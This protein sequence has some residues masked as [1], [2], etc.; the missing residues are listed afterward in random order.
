M[1]GTKYLS[2]LVNFNHLYLDE[3][4]IVQAPTGSGKTYFTLHTIPEMCKDPLHQALYLIDTIN[5]K[6]QILKNYNARPA[7]YN[8]INDIAEGYGC[9]WETHDE[10]VVIM[11]YALF[12]EIL[13]SK[14]D[15]GKHFQ[16]IICDELP[17]LIKF[18]N[19]SRKPNSHSIAKEELEHITTSNTTIVIALTATPRPVFK[20]FKAPCRLIPIDQGELRHYETKTTKHYYSI[21]HLISTMDVSERGLCFAS[22]I[23]TMKDIEAMAVAHEE[24]DTAI[25]ENEEF[26][27]TDNDNSNDSMSVSELVEEINETDEAVEDETALLK[28]E[29]AKKIKLSASSITVEW[30]S[31]FEL[32]AYLEGD[33]REQI[34]WNSAYFNPSVEFSMPG[35]TV[36]FKPDWNPGTYKIHA[37]ANNGYETAECEVT[38]TVPEASVRYRTHVQKIGWQ[39]YVQDGEL[40]GTTG[41]SLRLE[42]INIDVSGNPLIHEESLSYRTHVQTYG[43]QAWKENNEMA[44]TSGES[45][46]LEAIRIELDSEFYDIYYQTHVQHFGWT[47]WACNGEDCG[48]AGY[49]YRLE[50]IRIKLV[51]KGD[52][53]PGNTLNRYYV[54]PSSGAAY[55]SPE[56]KIAGALIGYNTH[57]QSYGWQSWVQYGE[58]SG[59]YGLGKRLEG[60]QI[61]LTGNL[62]KNY[63]IYYCVHAQTYGWLD[64]AKNGEMA[65]TAGLSKRLEGIKIL[66]VEKGGKAPGSTKRPYV[67]GPGGRLPDNPYVERIL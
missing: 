10:H 59:T 28:T 43:W 18:Q 13:K 4:N 2:E 9:A 36:V 34:V 23:T 7:T 37:S 58:V 6:E 33:E 5:G 57:V 40:S 21:R 27:K 60:I 17:S 61:Y 52:P 8:W 47:G 19:F 42:A 15:F 16:Y 14:P 54:N 38:V 30:G 11:T 48:S 45:K 44:G 65:G 66:L 63:D 64:W 49:G 46:R 22:R 67:L 35:E 20:S 41:Q 26:I 29:N 31:S 39:P 25:V 51:R 55:L 3:L 1:L 24:I 50:G 56:P 62:A 12:G 32:T 53:A